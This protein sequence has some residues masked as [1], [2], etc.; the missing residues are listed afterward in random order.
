ML[1][2]TVLENQRNLWAELS[3]MSVTAQLE[4]LTGPLRTAGLA[5]TDIHL[6]D[7][8]G[9]GDQAIAVDF[10][11]QRMPTAQEAWARLPPE[12]NGTTGFFSRAGALVSLGVFSTDENPTRDWMHYAQMMDA[13]LASAPARQ[14]TI[15]LV[16]EADWSGIPALERP[17]VLQRTLQ[18]EAQRVTDAGL[19]LRSIQPEGSERIRIEVVGV[20][21]PT[22]IGLLLETPARL[23]FREEVAQPDG[24]TAWVPV[25]ATGDDNS[26]RELTGTYFRRAELSSESQS[27]RPLIL[28]EFTDEGARMLRQATERLVGQ[29][30]GIFLD[31]QLVT[32][33]VVREPIS[34]GRSQISG[35]FTAQQARSLVIQ[36]NSGALPIPVHVVWDGTEP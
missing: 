23:E 11:Y 14:P 22:Q 35:Q 1:A 26:E 17:T 4:G 15:R 13:R 27:N 36:L 24:T 18:I 19:V 6:E 9:L 12:G 28:V 21:D 33:P 5:L 32:A 2:I 7:A 25:S 16:L 29:R 10:H 31:G 3:A 8:P 30:L 34:G 20:Q